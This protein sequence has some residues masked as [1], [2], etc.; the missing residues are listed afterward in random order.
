M[1]AAGIAVSGENLATS[2][3]NGGWKQHGRTGGTTGDRC[4][5]LRAT[6]V[7]FFVTQVKISVTV[8]KCL[9]LNYSD[10]NGISLLCEEIQT[11]ILCP[12]C[13]LCL[14]WSILFQ[15]N[16]LLLVTIKLLRKS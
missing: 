8:E 13:L 2:A 6:V 11:R 12:R 14:S 9:K 16:T 3:G 10:V 4:P 15:L 7:Q 5:S 1:I